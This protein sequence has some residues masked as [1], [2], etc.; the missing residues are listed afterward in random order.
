[1][2]WLGKAAKY[3][4]GI[5][6]LL[7]AILIINTLRLPSLPAADGAKF[8]PIKDLDA[9]AKRLSAAVQ[10]P[11]ISYGFANPPGGNRFPDLH[12]LIEDSF[13]LVHKTLKREVVAG[14]SLL[15]TWEGSDNSLPPI[16]L[17]AHQDVVPI[18]PGTEEKWTHPPFSGQISDGFVWGR[19]TLDNKQ[20]VMASLEGIEC[21]I[22]EGF[23]PKRTILLAFGHDEELG[24]PLGAHAI[25]DLLSERKVK[26]LFS[27]DEGQ[28]ILEGVVPGASRP[29]AQIGLSEKGF[30]TLQL[31]AVAPGGHSSMPPPHTAVGKLGHAIAQLEANQMPASL[32]GPGGDAMRSTA[33]ALPFATRLVMANTWLFGPIVIKQLS[34]APS[35]NALIRTTTA[36]TIIKGGVKENVLPS[37]ATAIVNFRLAPGDTIATVKAHV[38]RV[39]ANPDVTV[40]EGGSHPPT[41]AT[42]TADKSNPGFALISQAIRGVEPSA[43]ITPGLVMAGTDSKHYTRVSSATFYFCPVRFG[44]DDLKRPHATD[45]RIGIANYGEIISF[46][47][48]LIRTSAN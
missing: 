7:L 39:I 38:E 5:L 16:L 32:A 27:I 2:A 12:K 31:R 1:M 17:S 26:A 22:A 11:T 46:Y 25:A 35:T 29:I 10:I 44:P 6:L 41:E 28:A 21:L 9:A 4:G 23:K 30:M 8:P 19:G 33:P 14:S 45:E 34:G 40:T 24:G 42:P 47:V 36:P 3:L 48:N 18:E 13:P 43:L 15:Y 37:E 20:M